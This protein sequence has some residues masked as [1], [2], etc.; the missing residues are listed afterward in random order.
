LLHTMTKQINRTIYAK[1]KL[2]NFLFFNLLS[3]TLL[4][5]LHENA[6]NKLSLTTLL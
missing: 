5:C 6:K 1:T 2:I 3:T 4:Y